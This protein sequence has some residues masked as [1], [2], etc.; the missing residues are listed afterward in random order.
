[1]RALLIALVVLAA[2]APAAGATIV[3][4]KSLAGVVLGMSQEEVEAALGTPDE[5]NRANHEI[6]GQVTELRYGLTFVTIAPDSG[7]IAVSTT[8]KRQ[9]TRKG[10]G[11]GT[12]KAA[13]RRLHPTI[14]CERVGSF[15]HCYFGR[16][17]AGR[18]VT[19]FVLSRRGVVKAV[20]LG[21]VI[22]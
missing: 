5:A 19:D 15:N 17:L 3:P 18:V 22:D 13:L 21:R 12:T 20:R 1:M 4:G 7:V 10:A 11:V 8:S 9:K 14:R 16:F 2:T 6:I